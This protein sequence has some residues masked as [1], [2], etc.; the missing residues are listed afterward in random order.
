MPEKPM[1]WRNE[2]V[3]VGGTPR[4][5]SASAETTVGGR[6]PRGRHRGTSTPSRAS[7]GS[8][9]VDDGLG[10]RVEERGDRGRR[11]RTPGVGQGFVRGR[12]PPRRPSARM[13]TEV[14]ALGVAGRSRVRR[15]TT[16]SRSTAG[17]D[18]EEAQPV[19]VGR[20]VRGRPRWMSARSVSSGA[21]S[22]LGSS[23]PAPRAEL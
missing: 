9:S 21:P 6:G 1:A 17:Q 5:Q 20:G 22:G 16:A 3:V 13:L 10:V 23:D 18:I 11:S 8:S 7:I 12:S 19:D 14:E 4:S 2:E 15:R